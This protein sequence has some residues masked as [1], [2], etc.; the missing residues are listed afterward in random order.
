MPGATP[1]TRRSPPD[2]RPG[3]HRVHPGPG[4]GHAAHPADPPGARPR[5]RRSP[6][7][8][9]SA[10]G[11]VPGTPRVLPHLLV[12]GLRAGD[13]ETAARVVVVLNLEPQPGE[14]DGF[15]P[16]EHLRVLLAH[17]G[18]VSLHTV[19]ADAAAV[20]DRRGLLSAV[21][22]CGAGLVLAP[23]A[24]PTAHHD[25]IPRGSPR[26]WPPWSVPGERAG[27]NGADRD[28]RRTRP[29]HSGKGATR[30]AMTAMVKD[31]LARVEVHQDLCAQGGDGGAA[32]LRRRAAHR[33]RPRGHRGRARH[34]L[35][36]P[37]AAPGD[38]RGLRLR[39]RGQ[40][41]RRRRA[42]ARA[43][44]YIVRVAKDGEGL[45]RQTGLVDLRGR[46]VRGLPP[47][48]VAG[49]I[50]DAEAAWRGAFLAH[51]SLT[52][53]G[54]SSSLEITCP[55]PE[56]A[57]ALVGAGPPARHRGQ[58]PR[59]PRRRPGRGPGRRRDRRAAHP[60]RRARLGAGLG[61]AP[62]AP[63]GPGHRQ[64]AGQLRRRQPAPLG[65]RRGRRRRP[66]RAGA[67]DPRRRRARAPARR[68]A[69]CGWST[70]RPR[71]RSWA[72]WPT[73]R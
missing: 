32:A 10:S 31:E 37:P 73:R 53:P 51:G 23:V 8:T 72:R 71:W 62:D 43:V 30:M 56:A 68:P 60:A 33:R 1:T 50:G 69:G 20:V 55:G 38:R 39:Q 58:G 61:G 63:R 65:P 45:A 64:P 22:A 17:L 5:W 41:A 12:P 24:A 47:S 36:G 57:L 25:T 52:E 9:W 34:R 29:A 26:H 14:T 18:G 15:S 21:Q 70:G 3:G 2:P 46:P 16:E 7:P 54:R 4:P 40:R 28:D 35:G 42:C 27:R 59:G 49:G 13:G 19:I 11:R 48:V 66:G 67:G 6:A 44:R